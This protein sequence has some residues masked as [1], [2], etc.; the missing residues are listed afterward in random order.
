MN[1]GRGGLGLLLVGAGTR[2]GIALV[3][4]ACIWAGFF[5]ATGLPFPWSGAQ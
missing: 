3:L 1:D 4:V 2:L 5:W